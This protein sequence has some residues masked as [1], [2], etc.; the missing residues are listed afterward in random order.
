MKARWAR[1]STSRPARRSTC[2]TRSLLLYGEQLWNSRADR[3]APR[4]SV[5]LSRRLAQD[6]LGVLVSAAYSRRYAVDAGAAR[7]AAGSRATPSIPASARPSAAP[8][9]SRSTPPCTP[10]SPPGA[11]DRRAVAPGPDRGPGVAADGRDAGGAGPA[12]RHPA[13]QAERT[14]AGELHLPYGEAPAARKRPRL[15]D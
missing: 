1:R 13:L 3:L 15:A 10:A 11:D 12:V 5:V 8:A 4:G 9:W 14:P 7:P 2:A 6:R